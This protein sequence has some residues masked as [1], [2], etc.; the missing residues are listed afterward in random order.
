MK[1]F[2]LLF[3]L[4]SLAWPIFPTDLSFQKDSRA[5]LISIKS[6]EYKGMRDW[7]FVDGLGRE[8]S[9]RG[10]NTGNVAK[11][12]PFIPFKDLTEANIELIKYR[13][14]TGTNLIRWLMS[15][16]GLHPQ[17]DVIN[18]DYL[19]K[20][21]EQ[22]K[23]ATALGMHILIDFHQDLFD[24]GNNG[25]I[26][27]NNGPPKW[28]LEA[29]KL[30]PGKCGKICITWSQNYVT[31]KR[32]KA[33]FN[34]FWNNASFDTP[35]GK[36]RFQD[37]YSFMFNATMKYL[38]DHLT[39][40]EWDYIV[41]VD[42]MN[43]P[44]PGDYEK[45]ENYRKWTNNKL[46]PWYQKVRTSLISLG[47]ADKLL[48]AEPSTFW[49]VRIPIAILLIQPSGSLGLNNPPGPGF[50]FNAHGYDEVRE[51]LGIRRAENGTYIREFDLFRDESRKMQAPPIMTEFGAWNGNQKRPAAQDPPRNLK[52]TFQAMELAYNRGRFAGFYS[53]IISSTQ[54][55]WGMVGGT[56]F[57]G[58]TY[59]D[60][61]AEYESFGHRIIER[62][63]PRRIQGDLMHFY[64]NDAGKD[65]FKRE[66]MN[67][68]GIKTEDQKGPRDQNALFSQNKFV[69]IVSR[70]KY[71]P[72]PTEI[73]LPRYFDISK[74][75]MLTDEGVFENPKVV[76][77]S[78]LG[79]KKL[80]I[81]SDKNS[82]Y[83]FA[84]VLERG[85]KD[86]FSSKEWEDLRQ[87]IAVRVN[88]EKSPLFFIGKTS[89]DFRSYIPRN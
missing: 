36:R 16:G 6:K 64:Y 23:I 83:H 32:V 8:V 42:P 30:P 70:G 40:H 9:F 3:L 51:A 50:V 66:E 24:I 20:T 10:W 12:P 88:Q 84:L 41:G 49:N 73:F 37:E 28:I 79:G 47:M 68:I 17:Q 39:P 82:P 11:G 14:Y 1:F 80:F 19:R 62:A 4:P 21:V 87:K 78:D 25:E 75:I 53:P 60:N 31:N 85:P 54:W 65:K 48:F 34:R 71:S 45:F 18:E 76:A 81:S 27:G 35:K 69:F 15:W 74:T 46:F 86:N 13:K 56:N 22:L 43:E 72:A 67:W 44:N 57:F 58:H 77:D 52:A 38:K 59:A 89:S 5:N 26:G 7:V 61:E 29:L 55:E 63:Y 33:A 2:I